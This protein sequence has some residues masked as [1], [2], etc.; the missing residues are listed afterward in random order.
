MGSGG[1]LA[2]DEGE[3]IRGYLPSTGANQPLDPLFLIFISGTSPHPLT[4]RLNSM[5][6]VSNAA[7]QPFNHYARREYVIY[8]KTRAPIIHR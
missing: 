5:K 7:G 2:K 6:E 1:F 8:F 4:L 3:V